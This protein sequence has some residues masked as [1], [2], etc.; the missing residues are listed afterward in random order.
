MTFQE[1]MNGL[2]A[3][4]VVYVLRKYMY[5]DCIAVTSVS[6][7]PSRLEHQEKERRRKKERKEEVATARGTNEGRGASFLHPSKEKKSKGQISFPTF[8]R[9]S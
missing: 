6:N 3:F 8:S 2:F 5:E 4:S 7:R 1:A 9:S